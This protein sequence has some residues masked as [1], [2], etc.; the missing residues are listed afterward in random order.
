M[1]NECLMK[2]Y[3]KIANKVR[4]LRVIAPTVCEGLP[5]AREWIEVTGFDSHE[6]TVR[7]M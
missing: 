3:I 7:Q 6:N 4:L 2:E 5:C 1:W